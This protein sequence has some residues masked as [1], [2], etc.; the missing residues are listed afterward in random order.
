MGEKTIV[1]S[2]WHD[3]LSLVHRSLRTNGLDVAFCNG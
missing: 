2:Y 3:V 1:F